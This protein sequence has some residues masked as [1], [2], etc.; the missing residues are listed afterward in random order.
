MSSHSSKDIQAQLKRILNSPEFLAASKLSEFLDYVVGQALNGHP[1]RIKQYS[2]AVEGLGYGTEF[3]PSSNTVVRILA[4]RI[5]RALEHYYNTHGLVDPIRID[6]P[7]G[8]YIPVFADN[9]SASVIDNRAVSTDKAF[10]N[11]QRVSTQ[12]TIAVLEFVNLGSKDSDV[13]M[14]IGLSGQILVALT[15]FSELTVLGPLAQTREQPIDYQR[16]GHEY[17]AAF[18]LLG[19]VRSYGST[20]RITVDLIETSTGSSPWGQ[21]FEYDLDKT[22]LFDIEDEVTSKVVGVIA[23]GLGVIFRKLQSE[24]YPEY[25]KL[26][27]VSQ[28][29][30]AYNNAWARHGV[31]DWEK[32]HTLVCMALTDRPDNA[33]LLALLSNIYYADVMHG[34]GIAPNARLKM[35]QLAL[36]AV[37]LDPELQLAQYNL[38]VQNAFF[39]RADDCISHA[40]KVLQMNPNH[41]R[42]LAGCAVAT[43]SVGAYELALELIERAKFLNPNF[44]G[45]YNFPE[46]VI[47]FNNAQYDL[48]W[49]KAQQIYVG[50][51]LW[52]PLLRAAVLGKLE[53]TD[54]A[55]PFIE[56]LLRIKPDFRQKP[57]EYIRPLFVTDVHVNMMWDGLM[58][59]GLDEEAPSSLKSA[60]A[61]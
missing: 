31:K 61:D 30:L 44:P 15:R 42:I 6:I 57:R 12:P 19:W 36:N 34:M 14:A 35:E 21:A 2:I 27:D 46:Y 59:A 16:L 20:V 54:E 22:P 8:R 39:N 25:I 49:K 29:V 1:Q 23:D 52:E 40:K 55:K 43:S 50:G 28:A 18:G 24:S 37:A 53:R 56:E 3:D 41:A 9:P 47:D 10:A 17:G 32:A 51:L 4:G 58:K 13:Q 45:W 5:R 38:V 48:A 11:E 26:N 33:L 7:K 60:A